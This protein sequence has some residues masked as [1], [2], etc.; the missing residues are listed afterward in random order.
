MRL[1]FSYKSKTI[2]NKDICGNCFKN[3][4]ENVEDFFELENSIDEMVFHEYYECI[5]LYL[6]S[7]SLSEI[8]HQ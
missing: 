2:P 6:S 4:G 1:C 3:S 8:H 5:S 7:L